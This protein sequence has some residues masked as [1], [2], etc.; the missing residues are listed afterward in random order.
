M[1]GLAL[2]GGGARGSYHIG[3]YMALKENGIK[4]DG[5]C[6]T[7]I[8]AVNA[9]F[10][11]SGKEKEILR[12]WQTLNVGEIFGLE[13]QFKDAITSKHFSLKLIGE[14]FKTLITILKQKGIDLSKLKSLLNDNLDEKLLR[15]SKIDFG[16]VTVR[17]KD[18]KPIR[19]FKSEIP[20]GKIKDYIL[21]SCYLP[22]FKA[23][24][25]IDDNYYIDGGF[26]DNLP[27]TMLYDRGYDKIY[28]IRLNSMGLTQK[29]DTSDV[30]VIYITPSRY[31]GGVLELNED[32]THGNIHM[33]YYD[34]LRVIKNYDG[35][36]YVFKAKN[37]T[38]Y[39]NLT[40]K[41][42]EREL[43]RVQN[44]FNTKDEKKLIIKA[45]EYVLKKEGISYYQIL[46]PRKIIKKIKK[47]YKSKHFVYKFLKELKL[48][49]IF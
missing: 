39:K 41:I 36:E 37:L 5:I 20:E 40:K 1:I 23:E 16:C 15:Q 10:L 22:V 21:A 38:Y 19:L 28:A 14:S 43:R 8:G 3:A 35:Y 27:I 11:A 29:I 12:I 44:F 7:S 4:F 31:L 17:V 48:P 34:T 42:P 33:G 26:F 18:M 9:A 45:I 49:I 30:E 32:I 2:E 46:T 25:I 6:G 47:T 13:E 24:K